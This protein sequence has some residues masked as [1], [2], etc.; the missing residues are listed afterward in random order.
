MCCCSGGVFQQDWI[1]ILCMGWGGEVVG[2]VGA[3]ASEGIC[4]DIAAAAVIYQCNGVV[5]GEGFGLGGRE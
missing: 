5:C 1:E 4:R 2:G 3:V